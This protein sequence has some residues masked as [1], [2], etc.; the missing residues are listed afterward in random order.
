MNTRRTG[1][2]LLLAGISAVICLSASAVPARNPSHSAR[3]APQ[4]HSP[5]LAELEAS[6]EGYRA[7]EEEL[8]KQIQNLKKEQE[9]SQKKLSALIEEQ[10]K[11]R[12]QLEAPPPPELQSNT[13]FNWIL[14]GIAVFTIALCVIFLLRMS[15]P[16]TADKPWEPPASAPLPS[17]PASAAPA[18]VAGAEPQ[19]ASLP[20][21]SLPDWDSASPALDSQSL[22]ALMAGENIR[23]RDSTIELAEIMLSFGRINSAAEALSDFIENYPKEAFAPWI[24][25]LEVYRSNGQRTEFDRIAQKLNK[26]FNVWTVDWDNF[27][28]A[29]TSAHSIET[30]TRVM[31]RIQE[32]WGTR[33]CQAYLQYLLRDTRD[34][35]RKG[36]PLAAIEDI[37]CL[38]DILEYCLGPYTGPVSTSIDLPDTGTLTETENEKPDFVA[39]PEGDDV[40]QGAAPS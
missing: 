39:A 4:S 6:V 15:K 2:S 36:F 3:P 26:T 25:L 20:A 16:K 22:K 29:R 5:S 37:L 12:E 11:L 38:N 19:Q 13:S 21:P 27:Y 9:E 1:I 18:T 35:T 24:K 40:E 33:E 23:N 30:M 14:G 28:D 31:G 8:R 32:L 10:K 17:F 34:E 7:T